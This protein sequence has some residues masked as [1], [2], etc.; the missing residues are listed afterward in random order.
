MAK[1]TLNIIDSKYPKKDLNIHGLSSPCYEP[2][3]QGVRLGLSF[4]GYKSVRRS[5]A[6]C[7]A[8]LERA[9]EPYEYTRRLIRVRNLLNAIPVYD[10]RQKAGSVDIIQTATMGIEVLISQ[11]DHIVKWDWDTARTQAPY[12]Y[13]NSYSMFHIMY[14]ELR[15]RRRRTKGPKRALHYFLA[16]LDEVIDENST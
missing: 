11:T 5:V 16:I 7:Q 9:V 13:R 4:K 10:W 12:M 6:I 1:W 2:I 8:Y 14:Q 15:E 3:W